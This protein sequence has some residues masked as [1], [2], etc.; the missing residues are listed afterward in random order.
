MQERRSPVRGTPGIL[1]YQGERTLDQCPAYR[2]AMQVRVAGA[3]GS[4]S[5]FVG[6]KRT[7]I[8]LFLDPA[9]AYHFDLEGR[10]E[11]AV[12]LD[13]FVRRSHGNRLLV[14]RRERGEAG[15]GLRRTLREAPDAGALCDAASTVA[16]AALDAARADL[17]GTFEF[18]RP[19]AG[20]ALGGLAPHLE[21]ASRF[22]ARAAAVEAERFSRIYRPIAI[23]P[24]DAYRALVLQAT[25]GCLHNA[26]RFC[27]F[28][29]GIE[30][31]RKDPREF[32]EHVREVKAYWGAAV[33]TRSS[34]FLGQANALTL[35]QEE[36]LPVFRTIRDEFSDPRFG[37]MARKGIHSFLDAFTGKRKSEG[38]F[39]TLHELGLRRVTLGME[40]ALPEL[41][42]W[43]RKPGSTDDVIATVRHLKAA[44]VS[45]GVVL[46]AGIG[47]RHHDEAHVAASV[48]A[49][50][51]MGLDW[52]DR[53]YVSKLVD[54]SGATY[55]DESREAGFEEMDDIEVERQTV[56]IAEGIRRGLPGRSGP[57]VAR[58]RVEHFVY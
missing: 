53:V 39:A 29:R 24:P 48:A 16:R 47:G 51:A 6:L 30:F 38:E 56:A 45:V 9:P 26:C 35:S 2:V 11:K 55:F 52:A 57:R 36:L 20:T 14:T 34:F 42:R 58:Y 12:E 19:D 23:L 1:K 50:R 27:G 33:A 7:G 13:G 8:D 28:Y 54:Y 15:G 21:G 49:V 43:L 17:P 4:G 31:R 10:L 37:A 32:R 22:D 3:P 41:L 40:T 25:E 46:L 18:A 44:G 5:V